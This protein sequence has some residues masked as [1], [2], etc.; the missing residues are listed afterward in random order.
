MAKYKSLQTTFLNGDELFNFGGFVPPILFPDPTAS[1]SPTP[2][3]TPSN[4]PTPTPS[5][6]PTISLTPSITPTITPTPTDPRTCRTYNIANNGFAS[7]IFNWTNC[8]GSLSS[9]TLSFGASTTICAKNGSVS[10]NVNG[11]ITDIGTCPLPT[12]TPTITSTSTKTPTPTQTITP[13][14]TNTPTPS[15]SPGPAF[16]P[17]AAA[18]LAEVVAQGGIVDATMSAATNTLYTALKSAGVYSKLKAFYPILGGTENSHAVEGRN[19]GGA[20]TLTFYGSWIHT[21]K[22]MKTTA[23]GTGNYADTH[24]PANSLTLTSNHAFGYY[25]QRGASGPNTYDGAG[26]SPYFILGHPAIEFF[27]SN[28]VI[29]SVGSFTNYGAALGTRQASNITKV[30]RSFD[31]DAWVLGGGPNSNEP[32]TLPTNTI[33]ISKINGTPGFES[34]E[35]YAFYSFGDGLSDA[36]GTNYY[37]AVLA[38]QTSLG[39]NTNA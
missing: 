15:V 4:T 14:K 13:T 36:E 33:T 32:T 22:G 2:S 37:N 30:F 29:T 24:Y 28:A 8:D 12:P 21:D 17:D 34:N 26:P 18:Y 38:F 7:T 5:I 35:R 25:N 1:P 23:V 27:S 9:T 6:T 16:D 19:P 39:R 20:Q 11:S 31:G 10:Y 3:I